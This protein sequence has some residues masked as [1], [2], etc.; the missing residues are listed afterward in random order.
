V[1]IATVSAYALSLRMRARAARILIALASL[2]PP[3]FERQA[4]YL[5]TQ[6]T[7]GHFRHPRTFSEKVNWR[8]LYDR[9]EILAD[10]CDKLRAKERAERLGVAVPKTLWFGTD[11]AELATV[12][13]PA[14]WV[15]KPNHGSGNVYFGYGPVADLAH[16]RSETR[17]WLR[18]SYAARSGEWAYTRARRGFIVEERLGPK[19]EAPRDYKFFVFDGEPAVISVEVDR[20]TNWCRRMYTPNWEPLTVRLG[21]GSRIR[22]LAGVE[23]KPATL[24]AMVRAARALG[25]GFDFLRIDLYSDGNQVYFGELTPYPGGGLAR[26]WPRDYDSELG[27]R[28]ILPAV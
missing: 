23:D 21:L 8:I 16:L 14:R 20:M 4:R 22:P 1:G 2:G 17:G 27:S 5:L 18:D 25:Q 6:H 7:L 26:F 9:R 15:L 28:W 10:T 19:D 24:P 12:P 3:E 13:L 11:L